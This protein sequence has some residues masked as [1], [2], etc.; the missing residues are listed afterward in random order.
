MKK[1]LSCIFYILLS[2]VV[3]FFVFGM[4]RSVY[5]GFASGSRG[6]TSLPKCPE[7][8]RGGK[9][10]CGIRGKNGQCSIGAQKFG[11]TCP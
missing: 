11:K 5:E 10:H 3:F 4:G 9:V 8:S 7:V 2:L 6:S 1:I